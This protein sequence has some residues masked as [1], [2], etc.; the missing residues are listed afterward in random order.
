MA[1]GASSNVDSLCEPLTVAGKQEVE[2]LASTS[3]SSSDNDSHYRVSLNA[4]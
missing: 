2:L 3:K 1:S 4:G